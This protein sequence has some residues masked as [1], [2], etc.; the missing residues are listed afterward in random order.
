MSIGVP[1]VGAVT[2]EASSSG[3]GAVVP[4]RGHRMPRCERNDA[5][6]QTAE[7]HSTGDDESIDP[8]VSELC[9]GGSRGAAA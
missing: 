6:E 3:V 2:H 1:I 5:I 4:D 9:E 8:L 7:D